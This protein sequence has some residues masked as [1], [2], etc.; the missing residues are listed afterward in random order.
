MEFIN[1]LIKNGYYRLKC[2]PEPL[3]IKMEERDTAVIFGDL[4][5]VTYEVARQLKKVKYRII[6]ICTDLTK[7]KEFIK[8]INLNEKYLFYLNFTFEE[9]LNNFI[10]KVLSNYNIKLVINANNTTSDRMYETLYENP[11]EIINFLIPYLSNSKIINIISSLH[12]I[13]T[14]DVDDFYKVDNRLSMYGRT[15]LY[16]IYYTNSM[17]AYREMY[18]HSYP[19]FIVVDVGLGSGG[20]FSLIAKSPQNEAR[21]V[22]W[23]AFNDVTGY[24]SNMINDQD[25]M[26]ATCKDLSYFTENRIKMKNILD[27]KLMITIILNFWCVSLMFMVFRDLSIE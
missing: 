4:N 25:Y 24:V 18:C 2:Y 23:C 11:V 6:I 17:N 26:N 8:K 16:L 9:T 3:L 12:R 27:F 7:G 19:S 15:S 20:F 21:D 13:A 14:V 5:D 1:A 22:L 10:E